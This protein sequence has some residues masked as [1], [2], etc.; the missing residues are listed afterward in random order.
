MELQEDRPPFVEFILHQEEDR[1]ASIANGHYTVKDVIFAHIM[2]F[3]GKDVVERPAQDWLDYI[4]MQSRAGRFPREWVEYFKRAFA[5]FK[6]GLVL[7]RMGTPVGLMTTLSPADVANL[8]S[9]KIYTIEDLASLTD[10]MLRSM[11]AG[12]RIL[13]QRAE[14]WLKSSQDNGK[15]TM[16]LEKLRTERDGLL[17]RNKEL[18]EQVKLLKAQVEGLESKKPNSVK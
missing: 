2:P 1:E 14:A 5:D 9:A 16:E 3:G 12:A 4:A 17:E 8:K 10:D 6:E 11:P 15:V 13:K 18:E 7:P